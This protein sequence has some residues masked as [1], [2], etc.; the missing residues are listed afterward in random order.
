[1]PPYSAA[2]WAIQVKHQRRTTF[3][4][5]NA[6]RKPAPQFSHISTL[7]VVWGGGYQ[8]KSTGLCNP[9]QKRVLRQAPK[10]GLTGSGSLD[11]FN[12]E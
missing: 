11:S 5:I 2:I 8:R 6:Q 10:L 4:F 12:T 9:S 3:L 1:M 7:N